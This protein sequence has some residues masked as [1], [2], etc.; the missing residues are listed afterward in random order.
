MHLEYADG[1]RVRGVFGLGR[2]NQ[3]KQWVWFRG[4]V[5]A[6]QCTPGAYTDLQ[7]QM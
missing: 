2:K 7:I 4:H 3:S 1:A 6:R 5:K